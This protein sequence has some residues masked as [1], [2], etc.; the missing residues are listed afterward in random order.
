MPECDGHARAIMPV[1][2][3]KTLKYLVAAVLVIA[4]SAAH[5]EVWVCLNDYLSDE[6]TQMRRE[7]QQEERLER[8]E[9]Q[10]QQQ[11]LQ[12]QFN[13]RTW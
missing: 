7:Q 3:R 9:R 2:R 4:T 8:L 13:R 6:C 12:Q 11:Q 5:A 1:T 10:Q